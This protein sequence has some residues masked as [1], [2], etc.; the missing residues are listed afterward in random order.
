VLENDCDYPSSSS[1][2]FSFFGGFFET[3]RVG[4]CLPMPPHPQNSYDFAKQLSLEDEARR[5]DGTHQHGEN[6][7]NKGSDGLSAVSSAAS[8][9]D[10][11]EQ[12]SH[13]PCVGVDRSKRNLA[14][15]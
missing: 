7:G 5:V 3:E 1:L 10:G 14:N 13:R 2:S 12:V 15:G 11:I 9:D 6:T 8:A 4:P